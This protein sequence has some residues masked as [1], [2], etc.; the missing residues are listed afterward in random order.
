MQVLEEEKER[1]EYHT[2]KELA[3]FNEHTL[4]SPYF[5]KK[6][7]KCFGAFN[8]SLKSLNIH[9]KWIIFIN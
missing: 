3:S 2:K 7:K 1:E 8:L 9:Y 5:K 6:K 4:P